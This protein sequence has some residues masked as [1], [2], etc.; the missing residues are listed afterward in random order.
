[1]V[2][3]RRLLIA[4]LAVLLQSASAFGQA[5]PQPPQPPPAPQTAAARLDQILNFWEQVTHQITAFEAVCNQT[6]TSARFGTTEKY[7][8]NIRL[9]KGDPTLYYAS[10]ELHRTD[11]EKIFEKLILNDRGL[12]TYDATSKVIN[13]LE[14]PKQSGLFD[15]TPIG[16][17]CG[18]RA[19]D[20]KNRFAL[21]LKGEDQHYF[22]IEIAPKADGDKASFSKIRLTLTRAT[23]LPRQLWWQQPNQNEVTFDLPRVD[24]RANHLRPGDFASPQPPPPGW[25]IALPRPAPRAVETKSLQP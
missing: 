2:A 8:G 15:N 25:Q 4:S 13:L 16:L 6:R 19:V 23:Y 9:L 1:M 10:L 7:S 5:P 11:D 14:L 20:V 12:W 24:A 3:Y 17:V 22:Y 21:E 18:M